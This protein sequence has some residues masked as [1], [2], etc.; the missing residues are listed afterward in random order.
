MRKA[1]FLLVSLGRQCTN[2]RRANKNQDSSGN[3][4]RLNRWAKCV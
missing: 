1:K 2:D 4:A 3:L